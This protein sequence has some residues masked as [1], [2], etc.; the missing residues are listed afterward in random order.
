MSDIERHQGDEEAQNTLSKEGLFLIFS[1]VCCVSLLFQ[2]VEFELV[3][4]CYNQ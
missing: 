1:L 4:L 3:D 2:V